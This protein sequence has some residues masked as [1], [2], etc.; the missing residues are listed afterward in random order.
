VAD[1]INLRLRRGDMNVFG[2]DDRPGERVRVHVAGRHVAALCPACG[3]PSV[4]TNGTGWRD[5]IDVVRT[6]VVTL[7]VCVRRF[8]CTNEACE[9]RTFDERFEGIDRGGASQRALA[10]FAD[11]ARG[12][13]TA[14]VARDLG[15]PEHYLRRAVG[16]ARAKASA[17]HHRR[18]GRHLAIDEC[19]LRK[20]FVYATVFSD[21]E[22]QV[23]IDVGP[24]RDSAVIW[25]FA[26]LYSR[27]ER[28][29]VAVVTM[30]CH[31][32]YRMMVRLAFPHALIVADAFHLH[33]M[34][35]D[36][37]TKVRRSAVGRIAK[38]RHAGRA[39]APKA[40]RHALAR[41]RDDLDADTS[42]RGG[43]Q[44]AEVAEVCALDADLALAYELKEAF[45][46][47]MAIGKS[48]D[49][50]LF[51]TCLAIFDTWCRASRLSA[52]ITLANSL[53]SWRAEIVNYA[54]TGG[55]NNGFAEALN[56][57]IKN[58]KRQAHGYAT[59][60][61]FRGQILWAFGEVVDPATGEILPLRYVPRGQGGT[62]QQP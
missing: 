27:A 21:P 57:L 46:A 7:S 55:A 32:S 50:E 10:F 25:A 15:V 62:H 30:D 41:A 53:R 1:G 42:D 58:Q 17:G 38:G 16:A 40:A 3:V 14:A 13:A 59:W 39:M 37:L 52:F 24:G 60:Q 11:L 2:T 29:R 22:R 18:L 48:G 4:D 45:R 28:A 19:G 49:A 54:R 35:G 56:H 36:A 51:A 34:A 9:Q 5:V 23:V 43:R 33:R 31:N 44:R 61:G 6:L 47:T 12:R 20:P 26:G 8:V